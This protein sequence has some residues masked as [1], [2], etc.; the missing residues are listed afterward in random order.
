MHDIPWFCKAVQTS[1]NT[2]FITSHVH[3]VPP[4]IKHEKAQFKTHHFFF[5]VDLEVLVVGKERELDGLRPLRLF[6][7]E[8]GG[9]RPVDHHAKR[10]K[11]ARSSDQAQS[12]QHL[13]HL[14]HS[15]LDAW[16]RRRIR[17]EFQDKVR[18]HLDYVTQPCDIRHITI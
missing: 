9:P 11:Q 17:A 6:G 15:G 16:L 18:S 3:P 10:H 7:A 8:R 13:V 1:P 2:F 14:R 4:P 12:A 5:Q